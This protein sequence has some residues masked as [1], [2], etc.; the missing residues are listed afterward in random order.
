MAQQKHLF[1]DNNTKRTENERVKKKQPMYMMHK[2][3]AKKPYYWLRWIINEYSEPGDLVI[4]PFVGSGVTAAESVI[5][6][7]NFYGCDINSFAVFLTRLTLKNNV[8]ITKVKKYANNIAEKLRPAIKDA[9]Q[10]KCPVCDN[11]ITARAYLRTRKG[12]LRYVKARCNYCNDTKTFEATSYDRVIVERFNTEYSQEYFPSVELV[13]N[14][15]LNVKEG[16]TIEDLFTSRNRRLVSLLWKEIDQVNDKEIKDFLTLAFTANVANVSKLVP[17]I[18]SRGKMRA[19]AWMTGFYVPEEYLEQNVLHYFENRVQRVVR[20]KVQTNKLFEDTTQGDV[21]EGYS[22]NTDRI[23]YE[24]EK[25]SATNLPDK[26]KSEAD[27]VF[28]DPPY[29]DTVPYLEQSILWNSFLKKRQNWEQEIVISD[30]KTRDKGTEDYEKRIKESFKEIE[31]SLKPEGYFALSFHSLSGQQWHSLMKATM[32]A[33]FTLEDI[34]SMDQKTP[35]PR[36][37]NRPEALEN[38][39]LLI[40]KKG[41]KYDLEPISKT[42]GRKFVKEVLK[43]D[44]TSNLTIGEKIKRVVHKAHKEK[45][46]L[47]PIKLSEVIKKMG[48]LSNSREF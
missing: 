30:S 44:G 23:T 9:Y 40:W 47:P 16:D 38:D 13:P 7:R 32:K 17:P 37:L 25:R 43:K 10:T 33:G 15:R 36:Q 14:S 12:E 8:N 26:L 11:K 48:T 21:V 24:I 28:A 1:Q 34:L 35:S 29:G 5:S 42:K 46:L 6:K 18:K 4:D 19:G 39:L 3:W 31:K 45:I 22:S 27:L 2:Y 41:E 20:G